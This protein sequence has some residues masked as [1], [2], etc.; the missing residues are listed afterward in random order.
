[1]PITRSAKKALRQNFKR[2]QQ[3]LAR[4]NNTRKLTREFKKLLSAKKI[5]EAKNLVPSLYKILDKAAKT[6]II[7]KNKTARVKSRL[8][9]ILR[10]AEAIK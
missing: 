3:N 9:K 5:K 6:N 2:R 4:L 7:K 1:M 10:R 8:M